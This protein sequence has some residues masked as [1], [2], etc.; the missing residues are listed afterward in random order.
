MIDSHCHLTSISKE[1]SEI[2]KIIDRA[3][4]NNINYIVD[5]GVHPSDLEKR[6]DILGSMENVYMTA[7]FY[8]DYAYSYEEQEL[9]AFKDKI[10]S[11]NNDKKNIY[12]IGE[13]GLDYYHNNEDTYKQQHLFEMLISIANELSL[14]I[15]VHTREAWN[16]T[17]SILSKNKVDKRGIIHC[18]S[19]ELEEAKKVLDLGYI[20][21]FSGVITYPKNTML[22]DVAKY[23]PDDMF[24]LETDA[25]YLTP[26]KVRGKKN[27]PSFIKYIADTV[28]NEKSVNVEK[29][30]EM[31]Y[32][33]A[34]RVL[35]GSIV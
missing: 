4:E 28:A 21:S 1:K 34:L 23:V 20:I 14:P 3:K 27:E 29:I 7:G 6:F 2:I 31:S 17:I 24:C 12:M 30:L 33:N 35:D 15:S 8:P 32:H 9:S 16:D 22:R 18:F 13:I 11:M 26:Q 10:I 25:P 19:G 5:I